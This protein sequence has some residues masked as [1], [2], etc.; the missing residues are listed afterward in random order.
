MSDTK[1]EGAGSNPG[2][3]GGGESGGGPYPNPHK[4]KAPRNDFLGHGGQTEIDQKLHPGEA[5]PAQPD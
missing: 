5:K 1:V 4:G 2:V 3:R